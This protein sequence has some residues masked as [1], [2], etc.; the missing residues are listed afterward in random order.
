MTQKPL[1]WIELGARA[2]RERYRK[3]RKCAKE[4][5]EVIGEV[6]CGSSCSCSCGERDELELE[7]LIEAH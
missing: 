6:C 2:V 4:T 7:M 1:L 3:Y 5:R